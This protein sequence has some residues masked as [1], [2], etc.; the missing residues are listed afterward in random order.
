MEYTID[1]LIIQYDNP[2][3]LEKNILRIIYYYYEKNTY[4]LYGKHFDIFLVV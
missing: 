3:K 2:I 1:I 4:F